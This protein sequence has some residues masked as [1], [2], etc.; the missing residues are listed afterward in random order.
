LRFVGSRDSYYDIELDNGKK[1]RYSPEEILLHELVGHGIP[2]ILNKTKGSAIKNENK[3]REQL[4]FEKR[5]ETNDDPVVKYN[6]TDDE[7]F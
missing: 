6:A 1:I 5:K 4:G 7:L 2:Q 3:I